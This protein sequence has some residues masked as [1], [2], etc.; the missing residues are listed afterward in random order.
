MIVCVR[1][2]WL[3]MIGNLKSKILLNKSNFL[4]PISNNNFESNNLKWK[5]KQIHM[6]RIQQ[7]QWRTQTGLLMNNQNILRNKIMM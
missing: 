6:L 7:P 2:L 5:A 3:N 4:I 1:T